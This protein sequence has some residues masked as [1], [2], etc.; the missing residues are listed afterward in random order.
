MS[1]LNA[2]IAYKQ[3]EQNES[4]LDQKAM[5]SVIDT[6]EKR[7]KT[8]QLLELEKQKLDV[9][10]G[11]KGLK[12]GAKGEI[13]ADPS[14]ISALEGAPTV[15]GV[16]GSVLE[17]YI[18]GGETS[19]R[20]QNVLDEILSGKEYKPKTKEEA[21]EFEEAKAGI[22][23]EA[24]AV[25][26]KERLSADLQSA[27]QKD[28]DWPELEEKYPLESDKLAKLKPIFKS[29]MFKEGKGWAA[30]TDPRSANIKPATRRVINNTKNQGDLDELIKNRE[31]YEAAGVDVKAILEYFGEEL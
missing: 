2:V 12:F 28:I 8:S 31:D 19:E 25:P 22:K 29:P 30:L 5:M 3:L 14:L 11:T 15:S 4:I 9:S 7:S 1:I 6:L 18:E 23:K 20:E 21:L 10:L 13:E 27:I 24:R 16:K 17:K 26:Y